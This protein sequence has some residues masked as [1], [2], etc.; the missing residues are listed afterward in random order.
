MTFFIIIG[1]CCAF[2][3]YAMGHIAARDDALETI[4]ALQSELEDTKRELIEHKAAPQLP[5]ATTGSSPEDSIPAGALDTY[6]HTSMKPAE[7][8][9]QSIRFV[10]F[11]NFCQAYGIPDNP[12]EDLVFWQVVQR[13]HLEAN[14]VKRVIANAWKTYPLQMRI[15]HSPHEE[16]CYKNVVDA[17]C[18]VFYRQCNHDM[19]IA[20]ELLTDNSDS[21]TLVAVSLYSIIE[22]IPGIAE[23]KR[24]VFFAQRLHTDDSKYLKHVREAALKN[25]QHWKNIDQEQYRQ[26]CFQL[27]TP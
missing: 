27:L 26:L 10:D 23:F 13:V 3:F 6:R 16:T 24:M 9:C 18:I 15:E 8:P 7:V 12:T 14:H 17:L 21:T 1:V 11:V 4:K 20:K 25:L 19:D 2:M 5:A 22:Q